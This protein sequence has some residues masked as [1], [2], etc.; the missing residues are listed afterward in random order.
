MTITARVLQRVQKT[1]R[2]QPFT[3]NAL[4]KYGG[5]A[6]VDQVLSRLAQHGK[7]VR[8]MRGVYVRPEENRFIGQVQPDPFKVAEVIARKT[9]AKVQVNGAEAARQFGLTTQVPTRPIFLT[10]GRTKKFTVGNLEINLKH[11]SSRKL[12]FPVN[13]KVGVALLALWHLGKKQVDVET[14]K[15]I[16]KKLSIKDFEKL[17]SSTEHMPAWLIKIVMQY[18]KEIIN[19]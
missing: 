16:K 11:V 6:A 8:L 2:G 14:L 4:L 10:T 3:P 12:P 1:P 15:T 9:H 13:S 18:E 5:R 19:V 7:I 17:I